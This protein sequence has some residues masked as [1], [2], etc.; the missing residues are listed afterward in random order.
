ML[1]ETTKREDLRPLFSNWHRVETLFRRR[2]PVSRNGFGGESRG[3][4][5]LCDYIVPHF[6]L[7]VK[8][9]FKKRKNFFC[10][11]VLTRPEKCAIIIPERERKRV[12][13]MKEEITKK[14]E[15]IENAIWYLKM[16][17]YWDRE[18]RAWLREKEN[19]LYALRAKLATC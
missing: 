18:D 11:K 10:K 14:I 5:A 13:E 19:E 6:L 17:D 7:F 4:L 15:Q 12:N 9:F 8:R 3:S 2:I 16:K 1:T